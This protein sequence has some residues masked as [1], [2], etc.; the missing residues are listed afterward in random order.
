[1]NPIIKILAEYM[2]DG[3]QVQTV[4][5]TASEKGS[6]ND[7]ILV[8]LRD[9]TETPH[10]IDVNTQAEFN[11]LWRQGG[12]WFHLKWENGGLAQE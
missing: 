8:I 11:K 6:Y 5:P 10:K 4:S 7:G 2:L 9:G 3:K 1:M 12:A